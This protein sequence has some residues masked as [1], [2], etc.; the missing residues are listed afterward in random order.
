M[1]FNLSDE[2][3]ANYELDPSQTS[4][5]IVVCNFGE[6]DLRKISLLEIEILEKAEALPW[7]IKK[8]KLPS[9][10]VVKTTKTDK[11]GN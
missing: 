6:Y 7:F 1:S 5:R 2:V 3:S 8:K 11:E 10:P 9:E 4:P